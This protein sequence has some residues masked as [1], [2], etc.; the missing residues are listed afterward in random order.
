MSI[1]QPVNV[2]GTIYK[3]RMAAGLAYGHKPAKIDHRMRK[4]MT[5][6]EALISK[7]W[8]TGAKKHASYSSW[9]GMR[10]RCYSKSSCGKRY[11]ENGIIMCD[12]WANNFWS[13]VEDMGNPPSK[14]HSID[15]IDNSKGYYKENCRWATRVEQQRN[16]ISNI[17]VGQYKTITEAAE[18]A[19]LSPVTIKNRLNRGLTAE[20][21]ISLPKGFTNNI[22]KFIENNHLKR[23]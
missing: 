13:F 23:S 14:F 22:S 7:D 18:V 15:R 3:S 11:Q 5:L 19:G 21:A 6:E 10:S 16:M 4:G 17:K 2:F 8:H 12:A 20:E 9:N 1:G